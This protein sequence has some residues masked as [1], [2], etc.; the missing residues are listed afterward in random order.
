MIDLL[1]I[2]DSVVAHLSYKVFENIDGEMLFECPF[3]SRWSLIQ[4]LV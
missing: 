3:I 4:L 1:D 2:L